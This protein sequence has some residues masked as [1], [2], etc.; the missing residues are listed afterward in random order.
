MRGAAEWASTDPKSSYL[1]QGRLAQGGGPL[2]WVMTLCG[3][4][5]LHLSI[6]R[7]G[8]LVLGLLLHPGTS[9]SLFKTCF[10]RFS[11][12]E[13]PTASDCKVVVNLV[14]EFILEC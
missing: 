1:G 13:R 9:P 14:D 10:S 8:Q 12:R 2:V 3:P 4:Q 11:R 7:P 6:G 5:F